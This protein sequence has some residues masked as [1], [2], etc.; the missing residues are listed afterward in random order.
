[1]AK[2]GR[3]KANDTDELPKAK[4]TKES[5]RKASRIFKFMGPHKW[6]FALGML[7]LAA[8]AATALIFPILLGDL[9]NSASISESEI[10]R[11]GLVLLVVFAAQAVASFFRVTLFVNVTENMLAS[12]RQAIYTK[13]IRMPMTFF[14]QRRVG[15][16]NS[17][18]SADITQIGDTFTTTIA[19]FLRQF[20]IIIGGT[21]LLFYTS[22]K[23]G[24]IML[25][26]IPV[27]AVVAVVFGRYIRGLSKKTQDKVADTGTILDETMQGILSVKA[28]TNEAFEIGRYTRS[29]NDIKQ[30]AIKGGIARGA[31][32]SFIIFCLF[33]S[34][35]LLIWN[36][37][38]LQH[39]H[40]LTFGSMIQFIMFTI[41][42]GASIGGIAEQYS[43]IQRALG[44]TERTMDLLDEATEDILLE[45]QEK[46]A[47][48][49]RF[50]G[51]VEFDHLSFF[52]PS[53]PEYQVLKDVSFKVNKGDTVAI[54]GPSGSGKSTIASLLLRFYDPQSGRIIIDGK[55]ADQ[56]SLTELRSQMAIV[57][58]DVLLFG[59][60]IKE[61]IAYG[62][63]GA[64]MEEIIEAAKKANAYNFIE[65]FPQK[66]DTIVGERGIQLSGGQRQRIAIARAVLKDP[67]IL[68]LDEATSSL[69]SES[70]K[71][72]QEALDKLMVGR[73]SFVIA[74]R[75]ST[76]R[77]ADKIVVI[78]NG[79]VRES[80]THEEL[81]SMDNG[82]YK[83]LTRLQ[84]DWQH[85][86][87]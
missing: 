1:M 44:A 37:M 19:E 79:V 30:F 53:R 50:N 25:A 56:Y 32:I 73:T 38:K 68:I 49:N 29:V 22:Y 80:G 28:F 2:K 12:I 62:K 10:N 70:E 39:D 83:S 58:Q 75:L 11:V 16:L 87:Q 74:H 57:P 81:V 36:A 48:V 31:F 86:N 46:R 43:Q 64:S 9:V 47:A 40:Q 7:F 33:G 59:G 63:P 13:L 21:I 34:I 6:K 26:T 45:E 82:L 69:D 8:T 42:I 41:F 4:F 15:E 14:A 52:Y 78:E 66:F 3:L 84:Y 76:I 55:P 51:V 23:L 35:I 72:V 18:L 71:V 67:S 27:V 65:S 61:N 85:V 77:N 17:R 24:L 54:V 5:I 20:A 60:S